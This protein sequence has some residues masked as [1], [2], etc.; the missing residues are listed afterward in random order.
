M[1]KHQ[2]VITDTFPT[3]YWHKLEDGR[4]QYDV[5][6]RGTGLAVRTGLDWIGWIGVGPLHPIETYRLSVKQLVISG[7][8]PYIS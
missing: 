8:K 4:I 1:N 7:L 6:P 2:Q 5:C 3:Q